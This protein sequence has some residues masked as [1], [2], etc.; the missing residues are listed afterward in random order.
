MN[1]ERLDQLREIYKNRKLLVELNWGRYANHN[2]YNRKLD[3]EFLNWL[4][5]K[6]YHE[7]KSKQNS[8]PMENI[9][10]MIAEIDNLQFIHTEL[11]YNG[12]VKKVISQSDVLDIINK[13]C[14]GAT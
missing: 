7:I 8:V 9:D 2:R 12:A 14:K 5:D 1:D 4:C 11:E 6:S 10:K 3:A 13:Y